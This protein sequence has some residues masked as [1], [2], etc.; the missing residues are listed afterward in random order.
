MA[1]SINFS[2]FG[3]RG[4]KG[5]HST[6]SRCAGGEKRG[7]PLVS[8]ETRGEGVGCLAGDALFV[9]LTLRG[10]RPIGCTQTT[11]PVHDAAIDNA[12]A[13]RKRRGQ[14]NHR[15]LSSNFGR[16]TGGHRARTV[17]TSLN[18]EA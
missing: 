9:L 18:E 17:A 4:P 6:L 14:H 12:R 16:R 13:E 8:A 3:R 1:S 11:R 2:H 5:H 15:D 10:H 7:P